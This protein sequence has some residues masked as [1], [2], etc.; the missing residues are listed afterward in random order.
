MAFQAER[1][2]VLVPTRG[3]AQDVLTLTRHLLATALRPEAVALWL[4]VSEDDHDTRSVV[5][6]L[7]AEGGPLRVEAVVEPDVDAHG[8]RFNRLRD[9]MPVKADLY[10][11]A[12]DKMRLHT[13]GWDEVVRQAFRATPDGL[14]LA[15]AKDDINQGQFG[16]FFYL[17]EAWAQVTGRLTTEWFPFW[18]DDTWV[19]EVGQYALRWKALPIRMEMA[20]GPTQRMFHLAF[21]EHFFHATRPLRVAEAQALLAKA[22]E[23]DPEGLA[24]AEEALAAQLTAEVHGGAYWA[25]RLP[26]LALLEESFAARRLGPHP[27]PPPEDGY[28]RLEAKAVAWLQAARQEVGLSPERAALLDAA[29]AHSEVGHQAGLAALRQA[30]LAGDWPEAEAAW[31]SLAERFPCRPEGQALWAL[32]LRKQG[33]AGEADALAQRGAERFPQW[34]VPSPAALLAEAQAGLA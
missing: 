18:Y 27:V 1:I 14:L 12:S 3:R 23:G 8:T 33:R 26:E 24:W 29:I 25:R 16:A 6:Q 4:Y 13:M 34:Q 22:H 10:A 2:A 31:R 9:A 11:I 7:K 21:W 32:A 28:W 17:S 19:N 15:F 20:V 5:A 30:I